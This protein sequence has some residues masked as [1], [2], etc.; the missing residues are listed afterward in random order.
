VLDSGSP[1]SLLHAS[2]ELAAPSLDRAHQ[3]VSTPVRVGHRARRLTLRTLLPRVTDPPPA[4]SSAVRDLRRVAG[5]PCSS[6]ALAWLRAHAH[7]GT[8]A[9]LARAYLVPADANKIERLL[10]SSRHHKAVQHFCLR[11]SDRCFSL[12]YSWTGSRDGRVL[13]ELAGGIQHE[14]Y[15][16]NWE[17]I[18]DLWSLKPVFLLSWALMED[19]YGPLRD[20]FV[21]DYLPEDE[22]TSPHRLCDEA[23]EAIAHIAEMPARELFVRVPPDGFPVDHLSSRFAATCWE[24][25]LLAAPWLWRLSG[26]PFLDRDSDDYPEPE[27][28]SASSVFRLTAEYREALRIMR[29][30]DGFNSWLLHAPA[31]RSR[32]AVQAALGPPSDRIST[33]LDLPIADRRAGCSCPHVTPVP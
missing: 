4:P 13:V 19:P 20:E 26:N 9:L 15:G 30:I 33:L 16:D 31:E 1:A 23:R 21:R 2:L 28:W 7:A 8:L 22:Q 17:E 10:R 5:P 14:G 27:P 12:G 29:A 32:A 3:R 6:E 25:L 24:P 11:F 18:G